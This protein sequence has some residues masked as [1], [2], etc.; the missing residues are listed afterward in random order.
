MGK[1]QASAPIICREPHET[2]RHRSLA[3]QWWVTILLKL[4]FTHP[5]FCVKIA[6]LRS[7][8]VFKF[9]AQARGFFVVLIGDRLVDAFLKRLT[10]AVAFTNALAKFL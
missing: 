3:K 4:V 6:C 5:T 9:V 10:D 1:Q 8:A 7:M 2:T